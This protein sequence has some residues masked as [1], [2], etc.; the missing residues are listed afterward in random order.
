MS[1]PFLSV[2]IPVYNEEKRLP[3]SLEQALDFL[4][5]QE[6]QYELIVAENG[7]QDNTYR[8]AQE[9]ALRFPQI[10]VL[11]EPV[12]GKG[13]A[14]RRGMLE[15]KGEY[16][17]MC[18]VDFSMP[19]NEIN[20]FLPPQLTD[21]DI[22]I[23]SREAPG[24]QRFREPYYRHVGGRLIN[25]MIRWLALPG[26]H[27]T[28]CGFKCFKG[29]IVEELFTCQKMSGWSF[30]VEVLYIA[31]RF[32]YKIVEIPIPWYYSTESKVNPIPD[33]LNIII[34]LLKL[35][36][37]TLKGCYDRGETANDQQFE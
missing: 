32:N 4:E 20:R 5:K 12:R 9:F 7:S 33:S 10:L 29:K 15:S 2:I 30:D 11:R 34:D 31:R 21:F 17:F 36:R 6:Y 14:V 16:R 23:A 24:A 19:V 27:D 28:Q 22:A 3:S 18:D 1:Q 35:R 25:L 13:L 8:I 26:L 37:N